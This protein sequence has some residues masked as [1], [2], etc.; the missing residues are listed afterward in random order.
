M[1]LGLIFVLAQDLWLPFPPFFKEFISAL[2]YQHD[3][4][5]STNG[6]VL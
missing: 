1:G 2:E 4:L 3:F 6:V 5:N